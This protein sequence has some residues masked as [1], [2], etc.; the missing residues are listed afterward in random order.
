MS[1]SH[2]PGRTS[3]FEETQRYEKGSIECAPLGR[4]TI[5]FFVRRGYGIRYEQDGKT[6]AGN[7]QYARTRKP[8]RRRIRDSFKTWQGN[9]N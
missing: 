7:T 6:W 5:S 8:L 4:Q 2:L 9:A 1:V 3:E